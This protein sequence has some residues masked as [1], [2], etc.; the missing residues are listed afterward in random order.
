MKFSICV[1][2]LTI[3]PAHI[4]FVIFAGFILDEKAHEDMT[5]D[6]LGEPLMLRNQEFV[7]FIQ[8]LR[9]HILDTQK[10]DIMPELR[11]LYYR[12]YSRGA[13]DYDKWI[14]YDEAG[15]PL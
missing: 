1:K 6:S 14:L 8:R 3:T 5:R 15:T 13:W 7:P 11:D 12:Q 4:G 9:P 2:I 10:A